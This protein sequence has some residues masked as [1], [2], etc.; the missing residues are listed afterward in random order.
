MFAPSSTPGHDL[1]RH[2]RLPA[3][4][5][6]ALAWTDPSG[7]NRLVHGTCSNTSANGLGIELRDPPAARGY[8]NFRCESLKLNGS[9]SVRYCVRKGRNWLVGVE[10]SGGLTFARQ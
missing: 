10:F 8:V 2:P 4:E 9:G 5:R 6:I 1:R 3:S 7:T